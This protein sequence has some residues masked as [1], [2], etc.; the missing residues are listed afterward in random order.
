MIVFEPVIA[1]LSNGLR[2]AN[3]S[4]PHSFEFEDGSVLPAVSEESCKKLSM[5]ANEDIYKYPKYGIEDKL[6]AVYISILLSFKSNPNVDEAIDYWLNRND[7]DIVIVPLP[8]ITMLRN[9]MNWDNDMIYHSPFRTIRIA[10][11]ITKK[12]CIDKFCI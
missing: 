11:R 1:T 4:S 7:I 9:T 2:V 12:I 3:F 8:V 6:G 5:D 10:D